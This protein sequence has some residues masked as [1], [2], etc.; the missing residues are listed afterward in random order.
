MTSAIPI[1]G[2]RCHYCSKFYPQAEV[3]EFG[4]GMVMCFKCQ[5]A[6]QRALEMASKNEPPQ[7]CAMCHTSFDD[8][9]KRTP[10]DHVP[11]YMILADGAYVVVCDRC[12]AAYVQKRKDLLGDTP[13]GWERK[14]K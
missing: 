11:M 7:E 3:A 12:E 10:G 1:I 6:H 14:L 2:V 5:E 13:F 8:I 4:P 9:A